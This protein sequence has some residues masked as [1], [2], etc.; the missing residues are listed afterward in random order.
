MHSVLIYFWSL[1][2]LIEKHYLQMPTTVEDLEAAIQDTISQANSILFLNHNILEEYESRQRKVHLFLFHWKSVASNASL[3]YMF[4]SL[5]EVVNFQIEA[6]ADKQETDEKELKS[7]LDEINAL[8][9]KSWINYYNVLLLFL[10]SSHSCF[11]SILTVIAGFNVFSH[12]SIFKFLVTMR[13][14]HPGQWNELFRRVC[15]RLVGTRSDSFFCNSDIGLFA[16]KL[17]SYIENP[18]DSD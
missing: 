16:G 12:V 2:V 15:T 8:K 4:K 6:L 13:L 10:T 14:S 18:C 17:A 5:C 3:F 7:R 11:T 9:V 1:L